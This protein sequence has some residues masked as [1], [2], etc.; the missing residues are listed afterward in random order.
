ME[1]KRISLSK[2]APVI[3]DKVV[4]AEILT[5][6]RDL[7]PREN[8]IYISMAGIISLTTFCAKQIFGALLKELGESLYDAHIHVDDTTADIDLIIEMGLDSVRQVASV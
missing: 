8:T 7:N 6:I 2:Y 1:S 5:S 4:G 3:S